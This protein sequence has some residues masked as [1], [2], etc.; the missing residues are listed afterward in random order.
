MKF[1]INNCM[2]SQRKLES[3][4]Y[5]THSQNLSQEYLTLTTTNGRFMKIKKKAKSPDWSLQNV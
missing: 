1:V 3:F 2:F 5:L 4:I